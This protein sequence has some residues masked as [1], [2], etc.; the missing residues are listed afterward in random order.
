MGL[1][2]WANSGYSGSEEEVATAWHGAFRLGV[3]WQ[4]VHV[5][6]RGQRRLGVSQKVVGG[7]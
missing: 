5:G 7:L 6:I 4:Q 1:N 2:I 3:P